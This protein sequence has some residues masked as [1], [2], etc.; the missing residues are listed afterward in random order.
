MGSLQTVL[1]FK[2]AVTDESLDRAWRIGAVWRISGGDGRWRIDRMELPRPGS[3]AGYDPSAHVL[4][5]VLMLSGGGRTL[6]DLRVL[7]NDIGLRALLQLHK[8]LVDL[9]FCRRQRDQPLAA[10]RE[11][12]PSKAII[13]ARPDWVLCHEHRRL[14]RGAQLYER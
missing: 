11:P 9:N 10:V 12:T 8:S 5:L 14:F 3:A 2:L 7:R 1:P 13:S 6:E 4:P